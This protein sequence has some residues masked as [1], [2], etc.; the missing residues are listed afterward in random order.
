MRKNLLAG[1]VLLLSSQA[2]L[3]SSW[4]F[5]NVSVAMGEFPSGMQYAG[6]LLKGGV[7]SQCSPYQ[8]EG[9]FTGNKA[10][11]VL[12]PVSA[13][14]CKAP[15]NKWEHVAIIPEDVFGEDSYDVELFVGSTK[16]AEFTVEIPGEGKNDASS[17]KAVGAAAVAPVEGMWWSSE[18]PGTGLSFNVDDQGRWFGALYVYD[19]SGKPT[20]L[21]LQGESLAYDLDAEQNEA[22]AIGLSPVILSEGGQCIECPWSQARVS[23]TGADAQLLFRSRTLATLKI[24]NWSLELSP[25][26]MTAAEAAK[27][28]VPQIDKQYALILDSGSSQQAAIVKA[29]PG[30]GAVFTGQSY[31]DLSCQDCLPGDN[32]LENLI[33]KDMGFLCT[34]NRCEL[35]IGES[36]GEAMIDKTGTVI[37]VIVPVGNSNTHVQLRRLSSSQP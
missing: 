7:N 37:D 28:A 20:F 31:V 32:G 23:D 16:V 18:K 5:E 36:Y 3:A 13:E 35:F 4:T 24:G 25:L 19:K 2:V 15:S 33:E 6:L 14:E 30:D 9:Y 22:Y 21:T 10:K 17:V 11:F 27:P 26:T 1:A 12:T 34:A 29:I 8:H